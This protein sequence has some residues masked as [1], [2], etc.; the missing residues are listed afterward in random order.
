M[1]VASR[2]SLRSKAETQ[3]RVAMTAST[4]KAREVK[5]PIMMLMG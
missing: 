3:A 5:N 2:E 4:A 1:P